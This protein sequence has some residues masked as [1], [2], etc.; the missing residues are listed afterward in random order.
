M[1]MFSFH[2]AKGAN[3]ACTDDTALLTMT[4]CIIPR[5]YYPGLHLH[6]F[7]EWGGPNTSLVEK[8]NHKTDLP[9][10]KTKAGKRILL[11]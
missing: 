1:S 2:R 10:I 9:A 7:V 11:K 4:I 5:Y 6:L 3:T 8:K